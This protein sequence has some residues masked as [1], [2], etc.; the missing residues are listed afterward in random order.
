L[1]SFQLKTMDEK[2]TLTLPSKRS[3]LKLVAGVVIGYRTELQSIKEIAKGKVAWLNLK[4]TH[5]VL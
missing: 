5:V 4:S 3:K 1:L 2:H